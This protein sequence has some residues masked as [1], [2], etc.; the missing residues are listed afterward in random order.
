[1]LFQGEVLHGLITAKYR[2]RSSQQLTSI[3]MLNGVSSPAFAC[4]IM[5]EKSKVNNR[6]QQTEMN[7]GKSVWSEGRFRLLDL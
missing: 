4:C 1:M 5:E 6:G 7:V 2:Q 3:Q